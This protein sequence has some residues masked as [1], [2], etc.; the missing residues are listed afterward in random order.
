MSTGSLPFK[1]LDGERIL[2]LISSRQ[3]ISILEKQ[4]SLKHLP[5]SLK[6]LRFVEKLT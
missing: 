5:D 6:S 4:I 1:K 2:L 3:Q